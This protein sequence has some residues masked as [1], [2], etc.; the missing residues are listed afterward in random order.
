MGGDSRREII[1]TDEGWVGPVLIT[2]GQSSQNMGPE[3]MG[4]HV[5][6]TKE[7]ISSKGSFS[8]VTKY[9]YTYFST[10]SVNYK[11]KPQEQVCKCAFILGDCMLARK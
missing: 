7:T 5:D 6:V 3:R 1:D 11:N 4:F 2:L 8:K 9:S 10:M